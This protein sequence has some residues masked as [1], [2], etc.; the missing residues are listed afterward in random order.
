MTDQSLKAVPLN[1]DVEDKS[2]NNKAPK[3]NGDSSM[4]SWW[5]D[6]IYSHLIGIDDELWDLVEKGVTFQ[7]LDERGKLS[8]EERKKFTNTEK[9]A[10]KKHHKVKDI[11][12]GC[13]SHDE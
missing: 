9:K 7:G 2:N 12:I 10:Y 1:Y 8:V 4:F 13:I 11:L 3:F 6:R 5:K